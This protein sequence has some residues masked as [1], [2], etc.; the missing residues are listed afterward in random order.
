VVSRSF[1]GFSDVSASALWASSELDEVNMFI[2]LAESLHRSHRVRAQ[3]VI[4]A[5]NPRE[6]RLSILLR[7]S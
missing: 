7:L 2:F 6:C 4:D 1:S 3:L 5:F